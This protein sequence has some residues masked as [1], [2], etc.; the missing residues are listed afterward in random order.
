MWFPDRTAKFDFDLGIL[1]GE[2]DRHFVRTARTA[3]AILPEISSLEDQEGSIVSQPAVGTAPNH[4]YATEAESRV[5]SSEMSNLMYVIEAA[6][7]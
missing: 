4:S 6:V 3:A 1:S 2:I 7:A 5:R